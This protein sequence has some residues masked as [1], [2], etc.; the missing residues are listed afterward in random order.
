MTHAARSMRSARTVSSNDLDRKPSTDESL[1][2][3]ECIKDLLD[4]A[5]VRLRRQRNREQPA[6]RK[7]P[8]E[9]MTEILL[10]AV[11]WS[12]WDTEKLRNLASVSTYWRDII[13]SCSRFWSVVDV[14]ASEEK[15]TMALKR[16]HRGPVD[17][18]CY[19]Y[20]A[21]GSME[22]FIKDV[23]S[24]HPARQQSV[25]FEYRNGTDDLMEHLQAHN[26]SLIDLLLYR[27]A[28]SDALVAFLNLS[29]EGNHLRHIDLRHFA[30]P[31]SSPRLTGLTSICLRDIK[32]NSPLPHELCQ[33]LY[34]SP[35]LERLCVKDVGGLTPEMSSGSTS[36]LPSVLINLPYL[37]TFAFRNVSRAITREVLARLEARSCST[38]MIT[39]D[40]DHSIL[41]D[42][43]VTPAGP[44]LLARSIIESNNLHLRLTMTETHAVHLRS[45]PAI[46][47]EWVCWAKDTPGVDV[48]LAAN[49]ASVLGR[50]WIRLYAA[51]NSS[52]GITGVVTL[53]IDWSLYPSQ[54]EELP[55]PIGLLR[56]CPR[57]KELLVKERRA[58]TLKPLLCLLKGTQETVD[59]TTGRTSTWF[60]PELEILEF[61][62]SIVPDMEETATE[63]KLLIETRLLTESAS[64]DRSFNNLK[65][66]GLPWTLVTRLEDI[67]SS[68]LPLWSDNIHATPMDVAV[69]SISP[70]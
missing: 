48:K 25:L 67:A 57:L 35:Q 27:S 61:H 4:R 58:S 45:N 31:W 28:R 17:L 40:Q 34:C 47:H 66:I 33:I 32:Y 13:L 36:E 15:R 5:S 51:L 16:N 37:G 24:I 56:F 21:S 55:I 54:D 11:D 38:I 18:W 30:L 14:T 46:A 12:W 2:I 69:N 65:I 3:I 41:M 64:T 8:P 59:R 19:G 9:M 62:A 53:N 1:M 60:L 50:S 6:I 63:A 29:P 7:L 43:L 10:L 68:V 39:G 70:L 23:K 20:P 22:A 52:G 44:G 26:S 49:S 42:P